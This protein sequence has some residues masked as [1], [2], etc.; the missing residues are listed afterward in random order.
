MRTEREQPSYD[1]EDE[2]HIE[3]S[4]GKNTRSMRPGGNHQASP[5]LSASG[6]SICGEN[7]WC[8]V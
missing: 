4:R 1:H 7:K 3:N 8:V 2:S 5:G 6:P